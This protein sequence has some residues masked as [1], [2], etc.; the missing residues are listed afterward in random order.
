M[1]TIISIGLVVLLFFGFRKSL[2]FPDVRYDRDGNRDDN[3]TSSVEKNVK[4]GTDPKHVLDL[5]KPRDLTK[6]VPLVI[7]IHGG[8]GD[9]SSYWGSCQRLA[10][11]GYIAAAVNFREDPPPAYPKFM[12]DIRK[13]LAFLRQMETVDGTK[14]AAM[15][16]SGGGTASSFLGLEESPQKV[17][18]VVDQFG[19]VD[20]TDPQLLS[21][22]LWQKKL[23]PKLFG[24]VSYEENPEFYKKASPITY[25][26]GDDADF[27]LTRS[28]NDRIVPR[29]Q[30]E[31]LIRALRAAGK[32]VPDLYEFNGTGGGHSTKLPA[33]DAE[34]LWLA[35]KNFLDRCLGVL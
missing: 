19:P 24:N 9:K 26:S 5:C 4:Y 30:P 1:K 31:R 12:E 16:G 20:F 10:T 33:G 8:G 25:V 21:L 2:P 29:S 22:P 11:S 13:A 28:V 32:V 27:F 14:T 23:F 34:T 7:L 35:Q 15:G 3:K 6:K 18:C 17:S